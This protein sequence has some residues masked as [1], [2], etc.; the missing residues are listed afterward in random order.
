[1]MAELGGQDL[2]GIGFGI[3]IDRTLLAIRAEQ[4]TLKTVHLNL[5]IVPMGSEARRK[6]LVLADLLRTAGLLVDLSFGDRGLKGAMKAADKSGAQFSLVIG[7]S[8]LASGALSLKEMSTGE[9]IPATMENL[10]ELLL[11]RQT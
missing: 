1:L 11:A 8:E 9:S 4:G 5:F 2:S 6:A 3:G 10:S 7:E